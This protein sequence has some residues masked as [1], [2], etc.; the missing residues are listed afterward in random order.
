MPNA[1]YYLRIVDKLYYTPGIAVGAGFAK[2]AN[3]FNLDVRLG[4]VEFQPV[5]NMALSMSVASLT[6]AR[7]HK[8]D[9]VAFTFLYSPTIGFRYYF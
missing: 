6:Y 9:N 4:A 1:A 2:G 3:S 7:M 5:K 8:T